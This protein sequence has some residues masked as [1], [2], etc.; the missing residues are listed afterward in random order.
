MEEKNK[1]IV[2]S[3]FRL[4]RDDAIGCYLEI[5]HLDSNISAEPGNGHI[6]RAIIYAPSVSDKPGSGNQMNDPA[7]FLFAHLFCR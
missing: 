4:D 7:L 1:E 6:C 2:Q 5:L 3:Y